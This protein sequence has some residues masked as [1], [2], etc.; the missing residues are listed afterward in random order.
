VIATPAGP[1]EGG[2]VTTICSEPT[3]RFAE[4]LRAADP[5]GRVVVILIVLLASLGF[6]GSAM[7][8]G[9]SKLTVSLGGGWGTGTVTSNPT[10]MQCTPLCQG[11]F[12][13]G[14][15]VTLTAVPAAGSTFREWGASAPGCR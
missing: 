3:H 15:T 9:T 6:A 11:V 13:N 10:G 8:A 14:T 5:R 4:I 2:A 1:A 7:A 12:A